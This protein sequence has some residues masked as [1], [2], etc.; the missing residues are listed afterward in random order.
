[1]HR[2]QYRNQGGYE[3]LVLTHTVGAPASTT[4]GTFRAAPRYYELRRALPGGNFMIQEQATFAPADGVSR[5]MSSAAEDNQGNLALGYS[6]S[7]GAAGGNI[8]PGIRFAGRL[9]T[10]PPGGL[11]QGEATLINGTGVQRSTGNRWG[12]YSSLTVDPSDDCTFWYTQ[13][14][15]TAAGQAASTVGWQTRI[16]NFKFSQCTAP[17]MGTL[18]G[19]VTYCETGAPYPAPSSLWTETFMEPPR[20]MARIPSLFRLAPTQYKSRPAAKTARRVLLRM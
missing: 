17:A 11:F 14:Y 5:W 15:Y 18:S 4:F 3:T 16:G 10:D 6:V 9:A 20:P 1:M 12:D 7:S 19:T 8:F 2:L 13:E